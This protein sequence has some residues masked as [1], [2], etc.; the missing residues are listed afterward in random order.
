MTE[1]KRV[2][3]TDAKGNLVEGTEVGVAESIERF[4]DVHLADGTRLRAKLGI[5]SAVRLHDQWDDQGN[6]IYLVKSQNFITVADSP[7]E[8]K[9]RVQ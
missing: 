4:C 5:S 7:D 3:V 1:G 6:P 9:R 8:F 2:K